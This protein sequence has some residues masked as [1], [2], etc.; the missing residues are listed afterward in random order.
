MS[1]ILKPASLIARP[2]YGGIGHILMFHRVCPPG[3]RAPGSSQIETSPEQ[4]KAIIRFFAERH[5]AFV[6]LDEVCEILQKR[7]T[8]HKFVTFTFDD[9][10]ADIL[11]NAYPIL[12]QAAVPFAVYIISDFPDQKAVLWWY[13]L[14]DLVTEQPTIRFEWKGQTYSFDCSTPTGQAHANAVLK[15]L[16]K[17]TSPNEQPG[18]FNVLFAPY[19]LDLYQ[20]TRELALSWQQIE[21]LSADDL[22][23]I[24]AHTVTHPVLANLDGNNVREEI[25]VS[26]QKIQPHLAKPVDH[27]AYPYGGL[28]ESGWREVGIVK[29]LDFKSAVTTRY[30]NIQWGHQQYLECLPR[31]NVPALGGLD[32]LELAING[33]IP[34]RKNRFKRLITC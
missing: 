29:E 10:Y 18:L 20:K 8:D 23:T 32:S 24:G 4:L 34:A 25:I 19:H 13:L 33:L 12:K 2:I 3:H 15:R 5:Y 26:R 11:S 6:S 9:G 14:D 31:L 1:T 28:G 17:L 7:K 21:Q 27:F 30:G 22:V 16:I